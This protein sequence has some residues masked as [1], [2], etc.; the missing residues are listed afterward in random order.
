MR[1]YKKLFVGSAFVAALIVPAAAVRAQAPPSN[2][3]AGGTL[4]Q[5]IDQRKAERNLKLEERDVKRLEGRCV[6]VQ[7]NVRE[8]QQKAASVLTKRTKLY[9]SI[10]AKLWV[11]IGRLKLAE[12]DTFD[13]EK[14]RI[15]LAEKTANFQVI[16][17][18]YQQTIDDVI[19]MNCQADPAGFKALVD[20][21]R[22]YHTQ[23]RDQS[24]DI[25]A[26]IVDQ[27]KPELTQR[28]DEL[29]PKTATEGED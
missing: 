7:G 4:A 9:Q 17:A 11:V 13:L 8:I 2:A 27:I 12:Q 20:T 29:K 18:N 25:R 22:I 21:A 1:S 16:S 19:V 26:Y 14:L 15:A 23:L 10:D 28:A 6:A 5:R 24:A 3:P